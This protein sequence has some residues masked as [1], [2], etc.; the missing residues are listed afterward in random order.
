MLHQQQQKVIDMNTSKKL[1]QSEVRTTFTGRYI[2]HIE[3]Q[4]QLWQ[5][6]F[7]NIGEAVQACHDAVVLQEIRNG[8]GDGLVVDTLA[9]RI[10]C[11]FDGCVKNDA[12]GEFKLAVG[13]PIAPD[14]HDRMVE[15][16]LAWEAYTGGEP[17]P[18]I[19]ETCS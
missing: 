13:K 8:C 5:R 7:E 16:V 2:S 12:D 3:D 1:D 19:W 6:R 9:K 10:V 18:F 14:V 17:L 15:A 4:P 11:V